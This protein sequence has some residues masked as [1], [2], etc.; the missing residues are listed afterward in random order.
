MA[1]ISDVLGAFGFTPDIA[2]SSAA[3]IA[4]PTSANIQAVVDAYAKNGQIVPTKLMAYLIQINEE[5]HPEDTYGGSIFPVLF[6]GAAIL[7]YFIFRKR[8]S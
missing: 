5:R 3:A 6:A 7:A 8:R 2:I 4:D 1:D